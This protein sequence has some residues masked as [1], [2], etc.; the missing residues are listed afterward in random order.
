MAHGS[1]ISVSPFDPGI[2]CPD[3]PMATGGQMKEFKGKVAVITG[4]ASGIGRALA[5]HCRKREMKIVLADVE[6]HALSSLDKKMNATGADVLSVV[7]DVAAD[8]DVKAL[9]RKTLNKYGRVDLLFCN[10]GV[11]T[12]TSLWD[13]TL[14][15]CKWVVDVNLWGVI[16]CIRHI[17]P[18]MLQQGS[19]CHIVN[20]SSMAG[21]STYH[22]SAIYHLTK[23]S[24]VALS[25]Q[26]HHDLA[27]RGTQIKVSVLCPGFVNTNIMDAERNRPE[28]YTNAQN[29]IP[30]FPGFEEME[31]NLAKMIKSGMP[32]S[33]VAEMVFSAIEAERFYIFTHPET[34]ALIQSRMD[35]MI[36]EKNPELP[37][38]DRPGGLGPNR[39]N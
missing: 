31:K 32:A 22:P 38:F 27:I 9:A 6:E 34:V 13:S 3:R 21:I 15:D 18:V 14:K 16:H 7:T 23:H 28:K 24:V 29:D 11:A 36:R 37:E 4:A 25:E 12:G 20:T 2:D 10:A 5:D 39:D 35:D 17:V 8:K 19:P 33:E 26:L 30:A 1:L